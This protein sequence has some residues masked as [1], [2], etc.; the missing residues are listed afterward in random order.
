MR[1]RGCNRWKMPPA[2]SHSP[3]RIAQ[4]VTQLVLAEQPIGAGDDRRYGECT[5]RERG[6]DEGAC[7]R[8]QPPQM[9][10]QR[11][12]V[13]A[14]AKVIVDHRDV[15]RGVEPAQGLADATGFRDDAE[16]RLGVYQRACSE[17]DRGVIVNEQ[18]ACRRP[19][20]ALRLM[21]RLGGWG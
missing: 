8:S 2:R 19:R 17:T 7:S 1:D 11:E 6:V 13:A 14:V 4:R 9:G 21:V 18:H 5:V 15:D 3:D 20:T 12:T 16:I 10:N